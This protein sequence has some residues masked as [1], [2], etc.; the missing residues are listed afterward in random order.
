MSDADA[1]ILT[2][3]MIDPTTGVDTRADDVAVTNFPIAAVH[4]RPVTA[5]L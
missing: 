3:V 1:T 5:S 4:W 2:S